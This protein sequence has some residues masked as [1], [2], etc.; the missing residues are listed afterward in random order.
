ME[1]IMHIS[2]STQRSRDLRKTP[3][4]AEAYLWKVIRRKQIS[5]LKFTRQKPI[6]YTYD[7]QTRLFICDFYC[8]NPKLVIE[9]D[10]EIHNSQEEYDKIKDEILNSMGIN[11]LRF[12]NSEVLSNIGYVINRIKELA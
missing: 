9:V 4:N 3:T 6:S 5:R 7:N 2:N 8:S 10:G 12:T 1:L 11:V